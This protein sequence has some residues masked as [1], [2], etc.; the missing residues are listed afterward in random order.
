MK[1]NTTKIPILDFEVESLDVSPEVE[2]IL[3][4]DLE[5]D[6]SRNRAMRRSKR[7]GHSKHSRWM[8]IGGKLVKIQMTKQ[9]P[10]NVKD[11]NRKRNKRARIARR[12]NRVS[13]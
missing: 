2:K 13:A 8:L 11:G 10:W 3:T 7:T 4:A 6:P 1:E 5:A 12:N 9:R